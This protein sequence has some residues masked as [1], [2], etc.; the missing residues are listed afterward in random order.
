VQRA[1][2]I[3]VRFGEQTLFRSLR[4]PAPE[5][6]PAPA[7]ARRATATVASPYQLR[8]MVLVAAAVIAVAY[9]L[10]MGRP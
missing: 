10:I 5:A 6:T 2:G 1:G 4:A 9:W 8:T 3:P 7:L